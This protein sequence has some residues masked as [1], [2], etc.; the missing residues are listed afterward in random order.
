M[1]VNSDCLCFYLNESSRVCNIS[2]IIYKMVQFLDMN[3][4]MQK[5]WNKLKQLKL[6]DSEHVEGGFRAQHNMYLFGCYLVIRNL[7]EEAY[8]S[9]SSSSHRFKEFLPG[10]CEFEF[11]SFKVLFL[12]KKIRQRFLDVAKNWL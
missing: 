3:F 6:F 11:I 10:F 9:L 8:L 12:P 2:E 4:E 5:R 7:K 1:Y